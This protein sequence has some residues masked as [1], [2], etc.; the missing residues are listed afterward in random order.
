MNDRESEKSVIFQV[1]HCAGSLNSYLFSAI[2]IVE[3]FYYVTLRK[4][5]YY[6]L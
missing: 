6:K 2:R 4:S 3:K 5:N 1:G